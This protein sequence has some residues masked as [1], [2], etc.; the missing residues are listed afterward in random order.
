MTMRHRGEGS[1]LWFR[2]F[3]YRLLERRLAAHPAVQRVL[4]LGCGGG[5]NMW[6]LA[7]HAQRV[8]GLDVSHPRLRA[9]Q[10]FGPVVQGG[11]AALPFAGGAFDVVYAAHVLHHVDAPGALMGQVR[12]CLRA[13]GILFLVETL[14]DHPLL[15]LGRDLYPHW[16]GDEVHTRLRFEGLL[17]LVR[18]S[19][20]RVLE[21]GQ[22]SV[23]F[24]LWELLPE[25]VPWLDWLTPL[26]V[27]LEVPLSGLAR[28]WSAHGYCVALSAGGGDRAGNGLDA[29]GLVFHDPVP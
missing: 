29:D 21:A 17:D 18:A 8:V 20:F 12:R 14:D 7:E 19:G 10:R 15:R 13:G 16:R 6:R 23:F 9:A 2:V 26:F 1:A 5:E 3:R 28:R 24:W 22:Y 11:A 4:D 25:R 27:A